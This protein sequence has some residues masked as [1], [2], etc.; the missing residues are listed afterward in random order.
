[1]PTV[2]HI[3]VSRKIESEEERQRLKRIIQENRGT[4]AGGFI[5]RT[6]GQYKGEEEFKSDIKYLSALW[7]EIRAKS[8]EASTA[9]SFTGSESGSTPAQ[10]TSYPVT[11]QPSE[12][13]MKSVC[14]YRRVHQPFQPSVVN[15]VKLYQKETPIFEEF[16]VQGEI[17]KALRSRSG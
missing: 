16:G 8:I 15:R 14:G 7:A 12:L 4:L 1:M 10:G 2:D 13:T 6:A 9:V 5:V 11:S 17:D 3:G